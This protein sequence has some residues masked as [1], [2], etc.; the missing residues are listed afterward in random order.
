MNFLK[1]F[2]KNLSKLVHD[3]WE[4][5]FYKPELLLAANRSI[6]FN[7]SICISKTHGA[8]PLVHHSF[9]PCITISREA[10]SRYL[11]QRGKLSENNYN[12]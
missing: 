9:L 6:Y 4:D 3:F 1:V 12:F 10:A 11:F 8:G 2:A 7:I 5:Y